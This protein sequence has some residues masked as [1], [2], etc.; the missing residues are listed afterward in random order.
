MLELV[1]PEDTV[2]RAAE[3]IYLV[4]SSPEFAR[5]H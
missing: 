4:M 1:P 3:A 5:Q 2:L